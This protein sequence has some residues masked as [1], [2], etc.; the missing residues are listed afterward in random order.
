[1]S[2]C[3]NLLVHFA[4]K[5]KVALGLL[6]TIMVDWFPGPDGFYPKL[7]RKAKE[8]TVVTLTKIVISSLATSKIPLDWKVDMMFLCLKKE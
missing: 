7:L 3:I 2:I 1:M 6:K 8:E 5:K 4:I